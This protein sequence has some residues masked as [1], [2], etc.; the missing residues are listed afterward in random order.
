MSQRSV[1]TSL[2][3]AVGEPSVALE[4]DAAELGQQ[5]LALAKPGDGLFFIEAMLHGLGARLEL[6][7]GIEDALSLLDGGEFAF[8]LLAASLPPSDACALLRRVR[9]EARRARVPVLLL[10]EETSE[11]AG[12]AAERAMLVRSELRQGGLLLGQ[13]STPEAIE[14]QLMLLL[15]LHRTR[16]RSSQIEE[17][18]GRSRRALREVSDANAELAAQAQRALG[19]LE[20][21]QSQLVQAAKL[22][23]LGELVA[24]VAH[25]I[26]NPLSFVMSH[27]GTLRRGLSQ[28]REALAQLSPDTRAESARLDER[29]ASVTLGLDR[30]RDLVVKLQTVSRLD[31]GKSQAIE[32]E[33]AIGAVLHILQH[34]V[35]SG[36]TVS[37]RLSAP[38]LIHCDPSLFNQ[39]LMNLVVNAI[40]A[41]DSL[42]V[43]GSIQVSAGAEGDEYVLRVLDSGPGI[44]P[45]IHPQVFEAFFT[46]K[47]RGKGTGLGL[48][49]AAAVVRKHGGTLSLAPRAS[50]GTEAAIRLP[51]ARVAPQPSPAALAR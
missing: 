10:S 33:E 50:G 38:G 29:L 19:Q 6:T 2:I 31:D 23:A 4:A 18:L 45:E 22:A 21:A 16:S 7:H 3:R 25:E 44:P 12:A 46:T 1:Q 36:V 35:R 42:E 15:E 11:A 30:I 20:T 34:R 32:V 43:E 26:N 27:L 39:C 13:R 14:C 5:V 48:A 40:D 8:V 37:T 28:S 49:I 41:L 9:L 24:G 51:I 47:P 17:Q